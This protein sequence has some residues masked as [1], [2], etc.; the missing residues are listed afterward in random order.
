MVPFPPPGLGSLSDLLYRAAQAIFWRFVIP[1]SL[2]NTAMNFK[3][4]DPLHKNL[5]LFTSVISPTDFR[6]I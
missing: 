6:V 4:G 1:L 3:S 2:R 5:I